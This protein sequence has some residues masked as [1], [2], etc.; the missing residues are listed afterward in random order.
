MGDSTIQS[1]YGQLAARLAA[2]AAA[3][4][5]ALQQEAVAGSMIRAADSLTAAELG[6]PDIEF[7]RGL[8]NLG[9]SFRTDPAT[10]TLLSGVLSE[11][12]RVSVDKALSEGAGAVRRAV[13]D[14]LGMELSPGNDNGTPL[15]AFEQGLFAVYGAALYD[16]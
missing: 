13:L 6:G 14:L 12:E 1:G 11:A 4:Q 9:M 5:A 2:E 16:S 3:R 10:G 15:G 7:A 8:A